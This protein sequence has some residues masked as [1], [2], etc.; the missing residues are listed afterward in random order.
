MKP[1]VPDCSAMDVALAYMHD[2][3]LGELLPLTA[4]LQ[5]QAEDAP[6]PDNLPVLGNNAYRLPLE[7]FRQQ[8]GRMMDLP[9]QAIGGHYRYRICP[10]GSDAAVIAGRLAEVTGRPAQSFSAEVLDQMIRLMRRDLRAGR[11][12]VYDQPDALLQLLA[13][14]A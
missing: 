8:A 3:R 1:I 10:V 14:S 2:Y 11:Q 6:V 12:I 7:G 4:R 5:A 9:P 13:R